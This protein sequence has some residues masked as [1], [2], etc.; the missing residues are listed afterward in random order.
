[1]KESNY[2]RARL[3]PSRCLRDK[4]A[5]HG[6]AGASPTRLIHNLGMACAAA[7]GRRELRLLDLRLL[8][9]AGRKPVFVTHAGLQFRQPFPHRIPSPAKQSLR[10][11]RAAATLL[12]SRFRLKL[13]P[14]PADQLLRCRLHR[15]PYPL[16][17]FRQH[18]LLLETPI[19]PP[20]RH[21]RLFTKKMITSR[22]DHF[23]P[24]ASLT[25]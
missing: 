16:R 10:A 2:G 5:S 12:L 18:G 11:P 7:N 15:L 4:L 23:P 8:P 3:Q 17:Q 21:Q 20:P 22:V 19:P 6:S 9:A 13:S 24:A 1:M 14:P 25:G